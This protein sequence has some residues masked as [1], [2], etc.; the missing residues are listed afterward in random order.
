MLVRITGEPPIQ[1]TVYELEKL[2][3]NLCLKIFTAQVPTEVGSKKYDEAAGSM[4]VLLRYGGGFP[5]YR[6]EQFQQ[7]LGVPLPDATQWDITE[8]VGNSVHPVYLEIIRQAA[9]G[10]IIHHD[11]TPMKVLELMKEID[12]TEKNARTGIFTSGFVSMVNGHNIC[13]FFTGRK[14]AGENSKLG[15]LLLRFLKKSLTYQQS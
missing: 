15:T 14:H 4:I 7:S 2:R 13:L 12:S 11:D 1:A 3:C 5:F 9:Q 6:L 10:N 8:G